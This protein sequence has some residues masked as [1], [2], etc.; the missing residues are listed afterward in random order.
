MSTARVALDTDTP[1]ML[2]LVGAGAS[3]DCDDLGRGTADDMPL[4]KDL[5][6]WN[7]VLNVY[8]RV[9]TMAPAL[10]AATGGDAPTASVEEYLRRILRSGKEFEQAQAREVPL[11]LQHR[12][13]QL[14][15]AWLHHSGNFAIL[16]NHILAACKYTAFVSLNYDILLDSHL[17][18]TMRAIGDYVQR[19]WMLVKP[20]GSVN[21]ADPIEEGLPSEYESMP[22]REVAD[23]LGG[24]IRGWYSRGRHPHLLSDDYVSLHSRTIENNETLL[25][26]R[27]AVPLGAEEDEILCPQGHLDALTEFLRK[28][29][30]NMLVIGYSGLDHKV[31]EVIRDAGPTISSLTVVNKNPDDGSSNPT[32]D[33][34]EAI[35]K[36]LGFPLDQIDRGNTRGF[37]QYVLGQ[38]FRDLL[39]KIPSS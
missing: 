36:T 16:V 7:N 8:R 3:Y 6:D 9:A 22:I 13:A 12:I 28:Y 21:W 11:Y 18:M 33:S 37:R 23:A 14:S 1:Y 5:F 27:I 34:A 32:A 29:P 31:L 20:H 4:V 25:F 10:R 38:T 26:P 17:P 35:G 24:D 15:D 2:V 30:V 39:A 19:E